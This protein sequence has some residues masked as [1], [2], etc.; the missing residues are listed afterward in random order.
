M[1][2]AEKA[3]RYEFNER[4]FTAVGGGVFFASAASVLGAGIALE[5]VAAVFG[6]AFGYWISVKSQQQP[7]DNT[8]D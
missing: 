3:R 2:T 7:S 6:V 5:S 4:I 1:N 8:Y